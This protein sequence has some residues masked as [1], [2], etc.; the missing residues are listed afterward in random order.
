MGKRLFGVLLGA[1]QVAGIAVSHREIAFRMRDQ[2]I[3]TLSATEK[4]RLACFANREPKFAAGRQSKGDGAVLIAGSLLRVRVVEPLT[5]C[6]QLSKSFH[7]LNPRLC[8][9][10]CLRA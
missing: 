2:V 7:V 6:C 1:L 5:L 8:N 9:N 3:V 4:Q 10:G